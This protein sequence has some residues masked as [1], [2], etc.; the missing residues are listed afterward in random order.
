MK[1]IPANPVN[2][3]NPV[4]EARLHL[5]HLV[6]AWP[7]A[8]PVAVYRGQRRHSHIPDHDSAVV[9][10]G[11][12]ALSLLAAPTH[13]WLQ[14]GAAVSSCFRGRTQLTCVPD[15]DSCDR[16]NFSAV[17]S[18]SMH[19]RFSAY[20]HGLRTRIRLELSGH[21]DIRRVWYSP[22]RFGRNR[23]N[24]KWLLSSHR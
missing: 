7:A 18:V 17:R 15:R 4:Y 16:Q 6:A 23:S 21:S 22:L 10:V 3:V 8:H 19:C 11:L 5:S 14:A 24:L 13:G 2:S 12:C 20:G 1:K 9:L